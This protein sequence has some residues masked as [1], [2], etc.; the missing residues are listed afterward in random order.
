MELEDLD[1]RI[2]IGKH[3]WF[4]CLTA[5]TGRRSLRAETGSHGQCHQVEVVQVSLLM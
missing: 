3:V 2:V 1:P 5:E 4:Q